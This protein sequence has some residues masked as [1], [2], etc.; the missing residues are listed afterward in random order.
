VS[1]LRYHEVLDNLAAIA[2]NPA[3]LPYFSVITAGGTQITDM[4]QASPST[5]FDR[6]GFMSQTVGLQGSRSVQENWT[7]DPVKDPER[8]AA[9]RCVLLVALGTHP[10]DCGECHEELTK[11]KVLDQLAKIPPGWLHLGCKKDV[12]KDACYVGRCGQRYV[13]VS[14]DGLEGLT[15]LTLVIMDIATVEMASLAPDTKQVDKYYYYDDGSLKTVEKYTVPVTQDE[16]SVGTTSPPV[17]K[18]RK[19]SGN[20]SSLRSL[21]Q[22]QRGR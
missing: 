13:W 12:P 10:D 20:F 5:V 3:T 21:I 8:L 22:L 15:R 14:Y 17:F 16:K 7:T 1:N 19:D 18:L 9:I 4:G 2:A 11:F 6:T